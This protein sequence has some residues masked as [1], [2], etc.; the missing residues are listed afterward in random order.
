MYQLL[1]VLL[2]SRLFMHKITPHSHHVT[3][4]SMNCRNLLKHLQSQKLA[5]QSFVLFSMYCCYPLKL[6]LFFITVFY[7]SNHQK[8]SQFIN[9][10]NNNNIQE[11][12]QQ[13]NIFVITI[14]LITFL[15]VLKGTEC[16]TS[17][18]QLVNSVTSVVKQRKSE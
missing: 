15:V 10:N 9:N 12:Q 14:Q 13:S 4:L 7:S 2:S 1:K 16:E 17:F 3:L 6:G 5:F 18:L 11:V 8:T